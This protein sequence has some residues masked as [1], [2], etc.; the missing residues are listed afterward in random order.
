MKTIETKKS[1]TIKTV[2]APAVIVAKPEKIATS[3]V[4]DIAKPEKAVA[5]PVAEVAKPE[6][7][8]AAPVA[9]VA[10]PVQPVP[11]KKPAAQTTRTTIMA[12]IDVGF[13]N[14]LYIRGEGPGLSWDKGLVMDCVEDAQW[15]VTISDAVGPVVFKFLVNDITW[16]VGTDYSVESGASI[17]LEPTF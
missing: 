3:P 10:K 7:N 6:K 17:T 12:K 1:K 9:A 2:A 16:C 15:I 14:A 13:G 8:A 4:A 11:A 5:A